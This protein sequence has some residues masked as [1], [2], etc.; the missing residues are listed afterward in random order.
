MS[1]VFGFSSA[2]PE[3]EII[4]S[5]REAT[6]SMSASE[7]PEVGSALTIFVPRLQGTIVVIEV[8]ILQSCHN[9]YV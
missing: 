4:T 6:S 1:Q 3:D 5:D 9:I 2:V 7:S 8:I